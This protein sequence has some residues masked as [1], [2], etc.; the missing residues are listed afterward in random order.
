MEY[1]SLE[2]DPLSF[3]GQLV[4]SKDTIAI[5]G[6]M[7]VFQQMVLKEQISV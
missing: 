1:S 5:L 3:N 2:I 7:M 6:K 4:F